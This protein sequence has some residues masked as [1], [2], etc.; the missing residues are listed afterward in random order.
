[1]IAR[2]RGRASAALDRLRV[3]L[4]KA[5]AL[6][7]LAARDAK[8]LARRLE[9]GGRPR[10]A[11]VKQDVHDDL[12][13]CPPGR[14]AA[15][16][17]LST[18]FRSGPVAL[19]TRLGADFRLVHAEADP[20]CRIWEQ[21]WT[22]CRW[23]P[24]EYFEGFRDHLPGRPYG[25]GAFAVAA[26]SIDW[27]QYDLVVSSDVS[28]PARITRQYPRTVWCYYVRE[29]KTSA[30]SRSL[31]APLDGQDV[32]LTQGFRPV[33]P[34]AS[35]R[36]HN[37]EFPYFLQYYGCFHELLG[38]QREEQRRGAFLEHHTDRELQPAERAALIRV[39]PLVVRGA[40]GS[41]GADPLAVSL[42][43]YLD[44]LLGS[45][46]FV[47]AAGRPVWG[48]SMVEAIAAGC[49][50]IGDP[51]RHSCPFLFEEES[52]ARSIGEVVERIREFEQDEARYRR[53]VG[54][55]RAMIDY[56]C[57][58]RPLLDLLRTAD[59]VRRARGA[60]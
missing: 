45:K 14:T 22:E 23:C 54:R 4:F 18:V 47:K 33:V 9:E 11:V 16:I 12:Y 50:A 19:F 56:L 34:T 36:P 24:L 8:A 37:V 48:N 3:R 28:V 42:R 10:V 59:R 2:I 52:S 44:G 30:Y 13:A 58:T 21:K 17:V 38:R 1:M 29:V 35:R 49:L 57:F 41:V 20:E 32:H 27:S 25:N 6:P 5:A 7:R 46:Y 55:Q 60:S 15:E 53:V 40:A 51:A 31:E 26:D 39:V 43:E